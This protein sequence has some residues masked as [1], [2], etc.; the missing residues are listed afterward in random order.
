MSPSRTYDMSARR[1]AMEATREAILDTAVELFRPRWYDEVTLAEVAK[2]AGV[3]TQTVVNHFGGKSQLYLAG[4]AERVAPAIRDLR[5][6][7]VAGDL[8]SVVDAVLSD[9]EVTGEGTM[10]ILGIAPR[11]PELAEV[12]EGG[13]TWHH[14][15]TAE[16][17]TPLLGH[18]RGAARR[19]RLTAAAT[20]LDVST[21]HDLRVRQGLSL[22]E[23]RAV[24]LAILE[25]MLSAAS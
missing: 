25:P 21:W 23:S 4:V 1:A 5:A 6:D 19:R 18:L 13:R 14:Q 11:I 2:A 12:V 24:L 16:H 7:A 17:L 3:S 8:G 10:R 9:Y 15:W 22:R 20:V